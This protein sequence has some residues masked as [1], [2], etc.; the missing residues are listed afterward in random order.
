MA[1]H[2]VGI[3]AR[4]YLQADRAV[5]LWLVSSNAI[6]EQTLKALRE[7][8]HPYRQVL[9]VRASS[10]TIIRRI[11]RLP[12]A[13]N[14]ASASAMISAYSRSSMR[15]TASL[16]GSSGGRWMSITCEASRNS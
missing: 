6:R 15:N 5:C 1:A 7:R 13:S 10:I 4:E 9:V 2:T 3:A 11:R 12:S 8:E 16:R 14:G